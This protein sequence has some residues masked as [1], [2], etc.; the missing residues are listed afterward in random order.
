[1]QELPYCRSFWANT[2]TF[3]SYD[4]IPTRLGR[5]GVADGE[6]RV[7]N[8]R[9]RPAES[10]EFPVRVEVPQAQPGIAL[11]PFN[12][13]AHVDHSMWCARSLGSLF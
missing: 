7:G 8:D 9:V 12:G 3:L 10:S 2:P 5:K 4:R 11:V 13:N 1:V 6:D